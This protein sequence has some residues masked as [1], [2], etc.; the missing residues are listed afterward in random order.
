MKVNFTE[1][2][3]IMMERLHKKGGFLTVKDGEK[4]NT[5]TISWGDIGFQWN[6]PIF[7]VLVRKSRYTYDFLEKNGQF[8]VSIPENNEMEEAL[9]I[10]GTKSGRDI[11]KIQ[12]CQLKMEQGK[13]VQVPV[14][15]DCGYIYECRVVYKQPMDLSLLDEQIKKSAYPDEDY[16]TFYYGEIVAC[17]KN[18]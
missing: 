6:K 9:L 18:K 15:G 7:T 1:N 14:V 3:D 13:E 10:C 4:V 8:T 16:H 17:Y 5:M 12:R 11:D 2:M